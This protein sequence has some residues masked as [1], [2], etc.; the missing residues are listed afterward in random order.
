[1]QAGRGKS[2]RLA[3]GLRVV[4]AVYDRPDT[5]SYEIVGGRRPPYATDDIR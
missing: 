4:G 2:D 3:L 1:M 5:A